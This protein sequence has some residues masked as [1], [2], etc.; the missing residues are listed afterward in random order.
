MGAKTRSI[1]QL[2]K[3]QDLSGD[4]QPEEAIISILEVTE[5]KSYEEATRSHHWDNGKKAFD[6]EIS[7]LQENIVLDLVT[8]PKGRKV[9]GKGVCRAKENARELERFK[10]RYFAKGF[11]QTHGPEYDESFAPV[12]RYDS[13]RLLL[14][15]SACKGWKPR[16]L[17]IKMAFLYGI[18]NDEIYI[19]LPE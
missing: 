19:E 7:S 16:Q 10:A 1:N 2:V 18:L 11:S 15:V 12:I 5:R 3:P 14:A 4:P 6:D 13:L 8:R 9:G 17:K